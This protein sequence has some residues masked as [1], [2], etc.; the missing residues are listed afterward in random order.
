[1]ADSGLPPDLA[2]LRDALSAYLDAMEAHARPIAGG[3]A[4]RD[5]GG[6]R[7]IADAAERLRAAAIEV[8]LSAAALKPHSDN[9]NVWHSSSSPRIES[10]AVLAPTRVLHA[11]GAA[12]TSLTLNAPEPLTWAG[13]VSRDGKTIAPRLYGEP[14]EDMTEHER[15][16]WMAR[17]A[18]QAL[19]PIPDVVQEELA[20]VLALLPEPDPLVPPCDLPGATSILRDWAEEHPAAVAKL[21]EDFGDLNVAAES[22]NLRGALE[23]LARAKLLVPEAPASVLNSL[24]ELAQMIENE[25]L[26]DEVRAAVRTRELWGELADRAFFCASAVSA[27]KTALAGGRLTNDAPRNPLAKDDAQDGAHP[28][29]FEW[30]M[31]GGKRYDIKKGRQRDVIKAMFPTW[32]AGGDGAPMTEAAILEALDEKIARLRVARLFK[33]SLALGRILRRVEGMKGGWALHLR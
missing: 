2:P 10:L 18:A 21:A 6:M 8:T 15:S 17:K 7:V 20:A 25:Y 22:R 33:D 5:L 29:T 9:P 4:P 11:L 13:A 14:R 30:I 16:E 26:A 27:A 3:R 24:L 31:A 23:A 12:V 19:D 1:M 32:K 28:G